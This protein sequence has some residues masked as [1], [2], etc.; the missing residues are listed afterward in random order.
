[1]QHVRADHTEDGELL[2]ATA[3]GDRAAFAEL[4]SRHE[5]A[6]LG[7]A[8]GLLG[9]R[10]LAEEAVQDAWVRVLLRAGGFNGRAEV[11]TWLYRIVINRCRDI[12]RL[13]TSQLAR[14]NGK[15]RS[16]DHGKH[17]PVPDE[18][19]AVL[20]RAVSQLSMVE[21]EAVLLCHHA[22]LTH[23]QAAAVLQVPLG[24]LKSRVRSGLGRLER[25]LR[26]E[27]EV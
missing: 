23:A 20:R 19:R 8:L 25:V 1:M 9:S 15:A 26:E 10:E 17:G 4:A 5:R 16:Q 3:A 14:L 18:V 13:E 7:V 22:D 11:R 12:T 21:R 27:V 6:L 24:T 2:A